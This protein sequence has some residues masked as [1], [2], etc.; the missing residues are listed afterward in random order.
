[1]PHAAKVNIDAKELIES[2][3]IAKVVKILL[4]FYK[5]KSR[6]PSKILLEISTDVFKD[7]I[8]NN[9]SLMNLDFDGI[10]LVITDVTMPETDGFNLV[11]RGEAMDEEIEIY[12]GKKLSAKEQAKRA[13]RRE[14]AHKVLFLREMMAGNYD[15]VNIEAEDDKALFKEFSALTEDQREAT[16]KEL[17]RKSYN[18]KL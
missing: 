1:M 3:A 4:G 15:G 13:E 9:P 10:D 8:F 16:L 6:I 5:A 18:F 17:Q 11:I 14:L 2:P 7:V 12:P